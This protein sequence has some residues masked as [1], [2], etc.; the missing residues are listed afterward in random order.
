M[1]THFQ[2]RFS[3]AAAFIAF[4]LALGSI[5]TVAKAQI[6]VGAAPWIVSDNTFNNPIGGTQDFAETFHTPDASH[7]QLDSL[8]LYLQGEAGGTPGGNFNAYV[9][10]WNTSTQTVSGAPLWT[11]STASSLGIS[12]SSPT[13]FTFSTGGLALNAADTYALVILLQSASG[14]GSDVVFSTHDN[15]Y[16]G[17]NPYILSGASLSSGAGLSTLTSSSF[18]TQF[19]GPYDLAFSATFS[20]GAGVSPVPEPATPGLLIGAGFA[21]VAGYRH[22]RRRAATATPPPA[23]SAPIV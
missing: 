10:E 16:A 7:A 11:S 2:V 19:G 12:T 21:L 15:P 5:A 6:T 13:A 3:R 17:G 18:E 4:A 14:V 22:L 8:T 20:G 1:K 23:G 9:T